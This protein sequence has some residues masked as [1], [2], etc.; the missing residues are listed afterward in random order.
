MFVLF[1]L[2]PVFTLIS[3]FP[4]RLL[5]PFNPSAVTF[6]LVTLVP[7]Y[8]LFVAFL[9]AGRYLYWAPVFTLTCRRLGKA[10]ERMHRVLSNG[11]L[12]C[13]FG[14]RYC[15]PGWLLRIRI[16]F[17]PRRAEVS[18]ADTQ[19]IYFQWWPCKQFTYGYAGSNVILVWSITTSRTHGRA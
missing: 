3:F 7:T 13:F 4:P 14:N 12:P 10:T 11:L 1:F 2:R 8:Y 18:L 19:S 15:C 6:L 17:I 5:F 16:I 9:T